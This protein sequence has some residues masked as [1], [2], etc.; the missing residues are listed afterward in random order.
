MSEARKQT[1]QIYN[2]VVLT[3]ISLLLALAINSMVH[4]RHELN[5]LKITT[6]VLN[7]RLDDFI[8]TQNNKNEMFHARIHNLEEGNV[9]A[10]ADRITKTEA[11][12]AIDNLRKWVERYYVRK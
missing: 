3:L 9:K 5:E 7:Q 1:L 11:L 12:A 10:T 4:V 2:T 8:Q 6:T